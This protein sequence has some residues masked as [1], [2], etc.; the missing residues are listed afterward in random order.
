MKIGLMSDTHDNLKA[1]SRAVEIMN[2]H[3]VG[4]VIHLGDFVSP[5]SLDRLG[6]IDA[7]KH[8]I[9]GNNDGDIAS[10]NIIAKR[11][12]IHLHRTPHEM[13]VDGLRLILFHGYGTKDLTLR[14]VR[15]MA[16]SG[17]YDVVAFGHIHEMVNE[18][19]DGT[20]LINPGEVFGL[21][22]GKSSVAILDTES[23]DVEFIEF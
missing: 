16:R 20:M 8:A 9:Y 1:M 7:E 22:S 13:E 6:D 23:R 10:L 2:E 21:L 14:I 5:F 3:K 12:G 18:L 19:V 4:M 17:H 11:R 15:A